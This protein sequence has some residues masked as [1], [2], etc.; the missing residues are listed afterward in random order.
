VCRK[1][2]DRVH[3]NRMSGRLVCATCGDR[4]RLR[5]GS[6]HSCAEE[7][8]LQARGRCYACYKRE[9]R[10]MREDAVMRR[11]ARRVR[12]SALGCS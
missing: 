1:R 3:R 6:C 7:K 11:A 8:V 9:W 5:I 12:R 2:K 4:A 10:S